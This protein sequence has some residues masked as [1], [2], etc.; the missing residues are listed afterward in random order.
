MQCK[1]STGIAIDPQTTNRIALDC[2]R[3]PSACVELE[4]DTLQRESFGYFEHEVNP[5]NGLI[6]DKTAA[7]WPCSIAATGFT[8]LREI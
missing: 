4:L 7:N 5:A 1:T 6:N 3:S 8:G 2:A